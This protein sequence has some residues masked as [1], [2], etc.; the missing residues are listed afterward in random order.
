MQH[1]ATHYSV[2]AVALERNICTEYLLPV[3]LG[4]M[5]IH[6]ACIPGFREPRQQPA[7]TDGNGLNFVR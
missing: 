6:F 5:L 7:G 3:H 4:F 2:L 1:I